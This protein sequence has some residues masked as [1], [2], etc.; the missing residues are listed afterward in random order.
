MASTNTRQVLEDECNCRLLDHN[1]IVLRRSEHCDNLGLVFALCSLG[2]DILV[3]PS[4]LGSSG[5]ANA[6]PF[7]RMVYVNNDMRPDG[8]LAIFFGLS[9]C[10]IAIVSIAIP[11]CAI[12]CWL[13]F[14]CSF[15][16][17][18]II[19]VTPSED[20]VN[21]LVPRFP[22][23]ARKYADKDARN[24]CRSKCNAQRGEHEVIEECNSCCEDPCILIF[25]CHIRHEEHDVE[26]AKAS[27]R[28]RQY[29]QHDILHK[30]GSKL[31]LILGTVFIVNGLELSSVKASEDGERE[32]REEAGYHTDGQ[33][34]PKETSEV[35][36][37]FALVIIALVRRRTF[38]LHENRCDRY[39]T[40]DVTKQ[41]QHT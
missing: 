10:C 41:Q 35:R 37:I 29:P 8:I 16:S 39:S 23:V 12:T 9:G 15:L 25:R 14:F 6:T 18:T 20:G 22:M 30:P 26:D 28:R 36:L 1:V 5:S 3:E 4:L 33:Q 34:P 24:N 40:K 38:E 2:R 32:G 31:R 7:V 21:H 13:G 11:I 27:V 19:V 17:L